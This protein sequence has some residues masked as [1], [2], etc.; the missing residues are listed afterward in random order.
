MERSISGLLKRDAVGLCL[1]DARYCSSELL[2][3]G[4]CHPLLATRDRI[5][6]CN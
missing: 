4:A 5:H 6:V 2:E 3:A 1:Y